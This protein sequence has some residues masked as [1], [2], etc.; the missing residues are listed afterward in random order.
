MKYTQILYVTIASIFLS[1][2]IAYGQALSEDAGGIQ[3]A[4]DNAIARVKP[5]LVRI[6]VVSVW[7]NQ[8]REVKQESSGS[9]VITTAEGHV[10]TNHHVAGRAKRLVCTLSSKEEVEADLIGTDPLSDISIIKLRNPNKKKYPFVEFGN[11]DN[12]E[13]GDQILAMGSPLALSQSVTMGIVSNTEM[14]IPDVFMPFK[15]TLEGEDVGSVVRWIGHDAAIY[16]G[17]S[18]GPLVNLKGE[19]IG[20]NEISFGIAGAIP[21]NLAKSIALELINQGGIIRSWFGF[22]VQ[23]L[24]KSYQG[25]TGVLVSGIIQGS[26]ADKAGLLPGDIIVKLAGY[27]VSVQFNEELPLFNQVVNEQIIGQKVQIVI[28]RD[29]REI[30]LYIAPQEREYFRP[31]TVELRQWGITVRNISL[32]AAKEMKRD[33]QDG[34]LVTS[35]RPGGPC[36]EAKPAIIYNDIIVSIGNSVV[37]NTEDLKDVTK[38]LTKD[39]DELVPVLVTFERY[40][41]QYVTV[42]KI[43]KK[44]QIEQGEEIQKAWLGIGIQVL[45]KDVAEKLGIKGQ[46]G[47][48]AVQVFED[49][50]A[51]KAGIKLGD[52]IIA[53][54]DK[55]VEASEQS[56]IE[57]LPAMIRR[58]AVG[59]TVKITLLRNNKQLDLSVKLGRS[60]RL[61]REMKKYRDDNFE[62][63]IRDIAFADRVSQMWKQEQT[64][65]LVEMV[66]DGSWAGLANLLT[67]D[68]ITEVDNNKVENVV[69][70]EEIM[71]DIVRKTPKNVVMRVVRGIHTFFVEMEP[72][73]E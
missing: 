38:E 58:Y 39:K 60:P 20:I 57:I 8:G 4:V 14:V 21:G 15:F 37:K 66:S 1:L 72:D 9:G 67:G 10:V 51:Q 43:G 33:N 22:E 68:L 23:P 3:Q 45:T 31:K 7:D 16:P 2:S 29:N 63:T 69:A 61:P 18:G 54:D 26:P 30:S 40:E 25:K 27:D 34:V 6:H 17:N 52:I 50:P 71:E 53:I 12:L 48:R 32:L 35:V 55:L 46:K 49:S 28:M 64:G 47:V 41:S 65:V 42:A 36:G 56:D 11:S 19:I 59:S 24:L 73:W 62:F 13:V 5:S 44:G 70:F